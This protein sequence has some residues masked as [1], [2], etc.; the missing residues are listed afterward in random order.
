MIDYAIRLKPVERAQEQVK[1]P[2]VTKAEIEAQ[3]QE[4]KT[5]AKEKGLT[6]L[7]NKKSKGDDDD[8]SPKRG[9]KAKKGNQDSKEEKKEEKKEDKKAKFSHDLN[10]MNSFDVVKVLLPATT[11]DIDRTIKELQEKLAYYL[12]MS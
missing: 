3:L 2:E 9:K 5:W 6:V 8:Y 1:A 4:D 10:I 11:D 7:E 12:K